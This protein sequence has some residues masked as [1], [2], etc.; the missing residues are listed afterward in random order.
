MTTNTNEQLDQ[1]VIQL[2]EKIKVLEDNLKKKRKSIGTV[3]WLT[4]CT[5]GNA[6]FK[7]LHVA[8]VAQIIDFISNIYSIQKTREDALK[9][10]GIKDDKYEATHAGA[11]IAD[12]IED[13]KQRIK[14]IEIN[15]LERKISVAKNSI[16]SLKSETQKRADG[17]DALD[18][19]LAD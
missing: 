4:N 6:P 9:I 7:S 8:T 16:E 12:W 2:S 13:S 14:L 18:K 17:I 15:D 11:P 3:T 19:L 1:R 5:P 10:L